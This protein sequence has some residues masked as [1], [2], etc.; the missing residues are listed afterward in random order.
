M[1]YDEVMI[2]QNQKS[3]TFWP[4]RLSALLALL[5]VIATFILV[6]VNVSRMT[7]LGFDVDPNT[8]LVIQV[9][10]THPDYGQVSQRDRV[11]AIGEESIGPYDHGTYDSPEGPVPLVVVS[12]DGRM[13]D[14]V[15]RAVPNQ[16]WL[17]VE[18]MLLSF[19]G[20]L[21]FLPGFVLIFRKPPQAI[22][23]SFLL[24]GF[25]AGLF[26]ILG[27]LGR[28]DV[29]WVNSVYYFV[30]LSATWSFIEFHWRYLFFS[31]PIWLRMGYRVVK[32]IVII[33]IVLNC[34]FASPQ[35]RRILDIAWI[36]DLLVSFILILSLFLS[37]WLKK[38]FRFG[39][40]RTLFLSCLVGTLPLVLFI[41]LPFILNQPLYLPAII[42]SAPVL[43]IPLNYSIL[44]LN[45][46]K[47]LNVTLTGLSFITAIFI[48][49]LL[50]FAGNRF[51]PG[52]LPDYRVA[53]HWVNYL[54]S[55]GVLGAFLLLYFGIYSLYYRLIYGDAQ[56]T[57]RKLYRQDYIVLTEDEIERPLIV[58]GR[59]FMQEFYRYSYLNIC[60]I[61]G[62][63]M[64]FD[65][66][67]QS[68]VLQFDEPSM[69]SL[70]E[71]MAENHSLRIA[72]TLS[73]RS[74]PVTELDR[75]RIR[76][77][78]IFGDD[79]HYGYLLF[80]NRGPIGFI[81]AGDR[82]GG[83]PF[84]LI[85]TRNLIFLLDQFQMMVENF[86]L[87]EEVEKTSQQIRLSGQQMLQMRENERKRIARDMHDNI[88]QAVTAFRYQLN[89]MYDT[90][91]LIITDEEADEL[92]QQLQGITQDI[93]DIV[94]NLRPP[95]LDATG[96]ESAIVSLAESY[97]TNGSLFVDVNV[98]DGNVLNHLS[99]NVSICLYRVLQEALLN[100]TKHAETK[101]ARV[102][103]KGEPTRVILS[104]HDN[105]K[106]FKPPTQVNTLVN[107]GHFGL[108]GVH[109][110]LE[111]LNGKITIAS[112]PGKGATITAV[113]PLEREE[114]EDAVYYDYRR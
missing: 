80:G 21:F 20:V 65:E 88:I 22:E 30:L 3:G 40:V 100:I 71:T 55:I 50:V 8:G 63:V 78:E 13:R 60:L 82:K 83:E 16:S 41:Y 61:D 18:R 2:Q 56:A 54:V 57:A 91:K 24:F 58:M 94:F 4:Y 97:H 90:E 23:F 109:E 73:E 66:E 111:T 114:I 25:F 38:E 77:P 9:F 84:D 96:L 108:L 93:R 47:W 44:L 64:Q 105:G 81:V 14:V 51:L 6:A 76:Y 19:F 31:P 17:L 101:I 110:F 112:K 1:V 104:V 85:E 12:P 89:E 33:G 103:L 11:L 86:M 52:G 34:F 45:R 107:D 69:R 98:Q 53:T 95:A 102:T 46:K 68:E 62:T 72:G 28:I 7:S 10:V 43:I 87:V 39:I 35:Y 106:G 79:P 67:I 37:Q 48:E 99:E 92:Q 27:P 26:L 59:Y 75:V 36:C 113:I 49:Q 70:I 5:I 32:V 15:V 42:V 29:R 74:I